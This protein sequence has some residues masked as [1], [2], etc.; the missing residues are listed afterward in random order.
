MIRNFVYLF[1]AIL[2]ANGCSIG[3]LATC[4]EKIDT[5]II[6]PGVMRSQVVAEL[7]APYYSGKYASSG[8]EYDIYFILSKNW[9]YQRG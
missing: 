4:P 8:K 9:L 1:L 7:G 5:Y 2:L 6:K 3:I